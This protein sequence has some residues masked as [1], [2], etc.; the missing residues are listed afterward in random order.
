MRLGKDLER[1]WR[2]LLPPSLRPVRLR[3]DA[4]DGIVMFQENFKRRHGEFR[5][6]HKKDLWYHDSTPG[7]KPM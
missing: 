1:R 3:H 6:A 4:D 2:R 7:L 5:R